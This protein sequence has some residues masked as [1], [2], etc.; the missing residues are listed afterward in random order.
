MILYMQVKT[1]PSN[2]MEKSKKGVHTQK[3]YTYWPQENN[4]NMADEAEK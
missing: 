4:K 2:N 1:R 3:G